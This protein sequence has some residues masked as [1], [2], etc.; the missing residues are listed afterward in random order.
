MAELPIPPEDEVGLLDNLVTIRNVSDL[1]KN[2]GREKMLAIINQKGIGNRRG[3]VPIV[4]QG[5]A[6]RDRNSSGTG[7]KKSSIDRYTTFWNE[8]LLFCLMAGLYTD[9]I[10][11]DRAICPNC[12]P[13]VAVRTLQLILMYFCHE[14][15]SLLCYPNSDVPVRCHLLGHTN[16]FIHCCS[17][18]ASGNTIDIF[19]SAVSCLHRAYTRTRVEYEEKCRDCVDLHKENERTMGCH[20]HFGAPV[21]TR[22]GNP[23]HDDDFRSFF[24]FKKEVADEIRPSR[25]NLQLLPHELRMI[26]TELLSRNKIFD[27]MIWT[28]LIVG[29]KGYLRAQEDLTLEISSFDRSYFQLLTDR[30]VQLCMAIRGKTKRSK[31]SLLKICDDQSCPEFSSLR[32]LLLWLAVTGIED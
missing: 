17:S 11:F 8:C 18:W 16:E 15:G 28:I 1:D 6:R 19:K 7:I 22:K 26:R 31:P 3:E 32:T 21:L 10:I 30:I 4:V 23:T 24:N 29:I 13:T 5:R 14:A 9:G 27:F 25:T 2:L 20:D 12:P